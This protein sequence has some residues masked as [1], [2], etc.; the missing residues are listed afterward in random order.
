MKTFINRRLRRW[1][2]ATGT[3]ALS[4]SCAS[5]DTSKP[6]QVPQL[7]RALATPDRTGP[8]EP[9]S[10]QT[11]AIL[12]DRMAAHA[13]DMGDLVAAIMV[14]DYP[15]ISERAN[16]I[17]SNVNLARPISNDATELNASIP[18]KFFVRQDQLR[19]A[20]RVLGSA[21]TAASPDQVAD[22]YGKMSE[23]CVRCHAEYRGSS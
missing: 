10:P 12:R 11:R 9:L 4:L 21:A 20:A 7:A 14:L 22:A 8:P 17:A 23:T 5:P 19:A 13:R 6:P 18:E 1:V 15:R 2:L 3:V 16:S